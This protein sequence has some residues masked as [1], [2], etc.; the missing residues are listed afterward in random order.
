MD[1][2]RLLAILV[3]AAPLFGAISIGL[4]N[5]RLSH[6]ITHWW[7]CTLIGLSFLIS[8]YILI[9]FLVG[10]FITWD[11]N[12]YTWLHSG[13]LNISVGF[14][15]DRLT[16]LMLVIV[17]FISLMVHVYSIG[18]MR[19]DAS[20]QRFFCY[21]ALFTFSMLML[22]MANNFAQLFFGW[23]AVGLLSYLLIGF[24]YKKKAA[25]FAS[26]KAFLINRV[27]DVGFIIGIAAVLCYFNSLHYNSVF[28]QIPTFAAKN[29]LIHILP[30]IEW[31]VISLICISLFIGAMAKSAQIPLHVWLPDSMEGP[32]P[33]SA[34]IHAATMVTAGI[35]M[36]A[37]MSPL[38]EYSNT[39]LTTMI[40]IG[41]ITCIFTALLALVQTDIKRIIAYSTLSQLGYM[42]VALGIS[43]Y[44]A[45]IFHLFTHA[46][47]KAL[48]FLGAGSVIMAMHHD[49]N[50]FNMGN[51]K[52]YMPVTTVMMI[53]GTISLIGFPG[54][55][56]FYSKDLIINA[57]KY[58]SLSLAP[59]AYYVTLFTV[60]IT[61]VYSLRLIFLVFFTQ[62][63]MPDTM[64]EHLFESPKTILA[65]LI[66]LAIPSLIVGGIMINPLL[67]NFFQKS[68]FVLPVHASVQNLKH[69]EDTG[70]IKMLLH[71]FISWQFILLLLGFTT[72]WLCYIKHAKLPQMIQAHSKII[73]KILLSKYGFDLL[74]E[75]IIMPCIR[76]LGTYCWRIGDII[77]IDGLLVNGT[78]NSI[79]QI[80]GVLKKAQTG[81]LSNYIFIMITG[82][83][84][85]LLWTFYL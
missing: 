2:L 8:L 65:P 77:C 28:V 35:F 41:S 30:G 39:A 78:A 29:Q 27:G 74:N 63:R 6:A 20:Y 52:K 18:Y 83:L 34:L 3:V 21:I 45:A 58:S 31:Q 25:N 42:V 26:L 5:K 17:T 60:F 48:L 85:L 47:F 50:I 76:I 37:R 14:L 40:A 55:A 72:A 73:N 59:M 33:I 38:F 75:N 1:E 84:A 12:I 79:T 24:W 19:D 54:T 9:G 23:E 16:A 71:G 67:N 46:F 32:T 11:N 7:A 13:D 69:A 80:A 36:V 56:G 81:Y 15:I 49:Q 43:A 64:R 44:S 82:V 53:V 68:L 62:E 51:L 22:V 10:K 61:T 57:T 66:C 70:A 4:L